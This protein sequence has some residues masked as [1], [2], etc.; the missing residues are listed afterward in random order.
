MD[1]ICPGPCF[2]WVRCLG[3]VLRRTTL[4]H[5]NEGAVLAWRGV[6]TAAAAVALVAQMIFVILVA[7]VIRGG[8]AGVVNLGAP[9]DR[10][11]HESADWLRLALCDRL[12][13]GVGCQ[14]AR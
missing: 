3:D 13:G 6:T 2:A 7:R 1:V 10:L 8:A 9:A 14:G 11:R 12:A 4:A 5:V